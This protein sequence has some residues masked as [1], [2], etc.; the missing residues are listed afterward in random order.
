MAVLRH[1]VSKKQ[2]R[3]RS[4]PLERKKWG[5]LEKKKDYQLRSQDFHRKEAHLKL[6]R[7][8]AKERNPDEYHH[9]MVNKKTD[10][11]GVLV[12]ERGNEELSN[13]AAKLLKTQ[14]S[15]YIK[16]L[17]D[18]EA[19][20]IEK[21]ESQLMFKAQGK[22][23]VFVDS[24]E[25]AEGFSAAKHFKTDASLINRRENRLRRSQLEEDEHIIHGDVNGNSPVVNDKK[26]LQKYKELARRM[27]RKQELET[28]QS[29]MDLQREL[30]KKGDKKKVVGK[31]GKTSWKWKNVRKK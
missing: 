23:Q 28:V 13:S 25:E 10:K 16:T 7:K 1:D 17:H 4:Q 12:S 20:K 18:V 2:H 19:K 9:G 29:E 22:H 27:E 21:L 31:D 3:E 11:H 14:D 30:M 6:L 24:V 15:G 8:K 5:L 26:R